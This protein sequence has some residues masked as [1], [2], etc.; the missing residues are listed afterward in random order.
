MLYRVIQTFVASM[1]FLHCAMANAGLNIEI[2]GAGENQIPVAIVLFG[3]DATAAQE[4]NGIMINDLLR[5][6]LFRTVD[7]HGRNPQQPADVDYLEWQ[8]R[9]A[10]R[11]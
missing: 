4:I 5:S 6:G 9:G 8:A 10:G 1:L 11:W 3:G 7:P 2:I